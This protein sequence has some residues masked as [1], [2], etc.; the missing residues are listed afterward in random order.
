LS[1]S[2]LEMLL[3]FIQA[4]PKDS[5][6]RFGVA[7]E[8]ARMGES[9]KALENFRKLWEMNPDY[10]AAYFQAGKLLAKVG[11]KDMARQVLSDGIS[12]ATRTKD[13]HTKSE[14]EAALA[15]L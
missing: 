13:L 8:Y 11:N 12:A 15:E 7:M 4:D 5:F 3:E 1:K 9:D 10:T 6:A 2:R 14:M